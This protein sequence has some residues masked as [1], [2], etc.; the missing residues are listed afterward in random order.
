ML[1]ARGGI[2]KHVI[3]LLTMSP[4][5]R[6]LLGLGIMM[7]GFVI[8]KKTDLF[9][10]WFGEIPWAEEHLGSSGTRTFYKL[11]GAA[12]SVM[13]VFMATGIMSDILNGL[14]SIFIRKPNP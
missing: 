12:V 5:T 4:L 10:S 14:A 2:S 9:R 11:F 3:L 1:A 13:G 8:L 7:L 6:I